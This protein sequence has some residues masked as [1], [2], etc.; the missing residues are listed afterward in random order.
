MPEKQPAK[1]LRASRRGVQNIE[2]QI[3]FPISENWINNQLSDT[4]SFRSM[5]QIGSNIYAEMQL[6]MSSDGPRSC[7]AMQAAG[8]FGGLCKKWQSLLIQAITQDLITH[9]DIDVSRERIRAIQ[10]DIFGRAQASTNLKLYAVRIRNGGGRPAPLPEIPDSIKDAAY[11]F[12]L[13]HNEDMKLAVQKSAG[14][15]TRE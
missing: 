3:S 7:S 13:K 8:A 9:L 12:F 4:A 15:L 1:T 11:T 6:S 2:T 5:F 10:L 14:G